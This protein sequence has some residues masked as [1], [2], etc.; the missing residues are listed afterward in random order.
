MIG[1]V[2][3]A[4][5]AAPLCMLLLLRLLLLSLLIRFL[6]AKKVGRLH[7]TTATN[8]VKIRSNAIGTKERQL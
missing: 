5:G 7:A 4:A 3:A 2:S 1:K 6:F 8:G